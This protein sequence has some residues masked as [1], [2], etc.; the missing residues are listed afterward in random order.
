[1]PLPTADPVRS[2]I[3]PVGI[4]S[5]LLQDVTYGQLRL[6]FSLPYLAKMSIVA[7][8]KS[9]GAWRSVRHDAKEV[10]PWR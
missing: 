2:Q 8:V 5:S 3:S 1:M 4:V 9:Y 10:R 6:T 7:Q